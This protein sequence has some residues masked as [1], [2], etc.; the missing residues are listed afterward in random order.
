MA[1]QR[2]ACMRQ[3]GLADA[4]AG[5][6]SASCPQSSLLPQCPWR[7][8]AFGLG[9]ERSD[10]RNAGRYMALTGSSSPAAPLPRRS[11][12]HPRTGRQTLGRAQTGGASDG[13][14]LRARVPGDDL[15]REPRAQRRVPGGRLPA[16]AADQR[17]GDTGGAGQ[18]AAGAEPDHHAA[19]GVRR[20]LTDMR[21]QHLIPSRAGRRSFTFCLLFLGLST[22]L[23][24]VAQ[25]VWLCKHVNASAIHQPK[26]HKF[27]HR[28]Q[29]C[30]HATEML[31]DRWGGWQEVISD[32]VQL[33]LPQPILMVMCLHHVCLPIRAVRLSWVQYP[34]FRDMS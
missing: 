11:P 1:Y 5:L 21:P 4:S 27:F 28:G 34:S 10:R 18:E 26:Q 20:A 9:P 24:P 13:Q 31:R 25:H 8:R 3:G 12:T 17:G 2:S 16:A 22:F 6:H 15:G 33:C 7:R 23:V 30:R 29:E 14:Q 19:A 32:D